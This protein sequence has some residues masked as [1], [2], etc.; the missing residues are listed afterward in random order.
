MTTAAMAC[1][2]V[3]TVALGA[4]LAWPEGKAVASGWDCARLS[5][6]A[7]CTEMEPPQL[8]VA[9]LSV[10]TEPDED[11]A[12]FAPIAD[13]YPAVAAPTAP[14]E[15]T[16]PARP[17][18]A[19]PTAR[20]AFLVVVG[21]YAQRAQA[22]DRLRALGWSNLDITEAV[23]QGRILYRVTIRSGTRAQA[24]RALGA[25]RAA[26]ISDAWLLPATGDTGITPD[27]AIATL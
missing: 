3:G 7:P 27:T 15:E 2:G 16:A 8:L 23:I 20:P 4:L 10:D 13:A 6:S 19:V 24:L 21:S 9:H 12:A 26:G 25:A 17:E 14:I 22:E 1:L 18:A 5:S 11:E